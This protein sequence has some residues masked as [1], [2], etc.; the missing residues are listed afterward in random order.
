MSLKTLLFFKETV[1][2]LDHLFLLVFIANKNFSNYSSF[3]LSFFNIILRG[4]L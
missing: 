4:V 3:S 1:E 2:S